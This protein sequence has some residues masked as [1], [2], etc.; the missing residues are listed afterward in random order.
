MKTLREEIRSIRIR[1]LKKRLEKGLKDLNNP[2]FQQW[3]P[4]LLRARVLD[5]KE[6]IGLLE[7]CDKGYDIDRELIVEAVFRL[8]VKNLNLDVVSLSAEVKEVCGL[9]GI[10]QDYITEHI[11]ALFDKYGASRVFYREIQ[12]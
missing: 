4:Y 8:M 3:R 6:L 12:P 11:V 7:E 10:K 5:L 1:L 9:R 2:R